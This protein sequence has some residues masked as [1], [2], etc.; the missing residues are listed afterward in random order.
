VHGVRSDTVGRTRTARIRGHF[1]AIAS[2]ATLHPR[3]VARSDE[4]VLHA[5]GADL[6]P[7]DDAERDEQP[8]VGERAADE[9]SG[10]DTDPVEVARAKCN[11]WP[12][13]YQRLREEAGVPTLD[14]ER[15]SAGGLDRR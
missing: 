7:A 14:A 5:D 12:R 3:I 10:V 8:E 1:Q 4:Q 9:A 13:Q 15:R 11:G 6:A 2:I